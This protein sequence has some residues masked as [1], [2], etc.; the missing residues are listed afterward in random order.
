M[1]Q[2]AAKSTMCQFIGICAAMNSQLAC[3]MADLE[4]GRVCTLQLNGRVFN[5]NITAEENTHEHPQ[6]AK[7]KKHG[8]KE[9]C[10]RHAVWKPDAH[11]T[12]KHQ[13]ADEEQNN[14]PE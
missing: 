5:F 1:L 10:K 13:P 4:V 8:P 14:S 11:F 2:P 12:G 7:D 3:T 9:F 6:A